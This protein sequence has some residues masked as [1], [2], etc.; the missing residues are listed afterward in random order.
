VNLKKID[1]L[2]KITFKQD[3]AEPTQ[4]SPPVVRKLD[5]VPEEEQMAPVTAVAAVRPTNTPAVTTVTMQPKT[6]MAKLETYASQ[7]WSFEAF[8]AKFDSHSSYFGWSEKVRVLQLQNS[9]TVTA[10]TVLWASVIQNNLADLIRLHKDHHD[11]DNQTERFG[12]N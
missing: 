8:L 2:P 5:I 10:A 7:G 1:S 9:L 4:P 3:I 11:S 6:P 12:W